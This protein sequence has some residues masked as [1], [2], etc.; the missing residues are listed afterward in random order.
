MIGIGLISI[1][2]AFYVAW[3]IGTNEET[4]ASA[5]ASKVIKLKHA[6][7]LAAIVA[8][9][10]ASL[11]GGLV[12]ETLR[13]DILLNKITIKEVFAI[14]MG[15]GLWL[16][17]CAFFGLTISTTVAVVGSI[18]G[19]ALVTN[20]QVNWNTIINIAISWIT[21][22][23]AGLVFAFVIYKVFAKTVFPR[24][25]NFETREKMERWFSVLQILVTM[26]SIFSRA[27][28]DVA[29]AIFFFAEQ[30]PIFYK[31]L[32]GLGISLG[33]LT[34]GKRVTKNLGTKLTE[35]SP[36]AGF[37]VQASTMLVMS[38]FTAMK[39]PIS[40]SSVFVCALAGAGLGRRKNINT[41]FVKEIILS[42]VITMPCCA[43]TSGVI[44]FISSVFI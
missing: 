21:S 24:I 40:G 4:F 10:G 41:K 3:G 1:L 9:L 28:N 12:S 31:L 16:S 32:G 18:L 43:I 37:A 11:F 44:Y 2:V 17:V 22:P 14:M 5:I 35:L 7:I 33:L 29:Q 25:N 13:E 27:A 30:D 39:I 34:M 15:M 36:S 38:V 6:M 8:F 26:G 23:I 19:V 42:R 20:S